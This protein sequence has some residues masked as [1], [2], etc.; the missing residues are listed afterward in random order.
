M[1]V[2]DKLSGYTGGFIL[3]AALYGLVACGSGASDTELVE[4]AKAYMAENQPREAAIELKN[5][6][7]SNPD[8]AEARYLLGEIQLEVGDIASAEKEFERSAE[9]GWLDELAKIEIA[10]SL[11]LQRKFKEMAEDVTAGSNW[12]KAAKADLLGL[13]AVAEAGMGDLVKARVTLLEGEKLQADALYVLETKAKLQLLEG[14]TSKAV[15]TLD[16]A[17]K[18]YP[19]SGELR[20]LA[21]NA[22]INNKDVAGARDFYE[23][24][25]TKEPANLITRN[26][27][28]AFIGVTRLSILDKEYEQ[29]HEALDPLAKLNPDDP[30]VNYLAGVLAFEEKDYDQAEISLR[31]ILKLAPNHEPSL[32]LF[33]AVSYAQ[34]KFEQAAY[35]LSKYVSARPENL[36]ARKLLGRAYIALEQHENAQE[37]L[38]P[39]LKEKS[40]DAELLALDGLSLLRSGQAKAGIFELEKAVAL[41]PESAVLRS[42][43]ARAYMSSG[44]MEQAIGELEK[45]IA[46]GK[47]AYRAQV[48]VVFAYLRGKKYEEAIA[49]SQKMLD[50]YPDDATIT[51]LMGIVQYNSGHEEAGRKYFEKTL[52]IDPQHTGAAINLARLDEKAGDIEKARTRYKAILDN[53]AGNTTAL[54]AL[55]R[56]AVIQGDKQSQIKWL[57]KAREVDNEDAASRVVL[58]ETYIKNKDLAV[59][60]K[61]VK[62]IE[63]MHEGKP[64]A[65]IARAE[66]LMAR[67]SH[68]QA[69]SVIN[70]LVELRPDSFVGY[71]LKGMNQ[72]KLGQVEDAKT[73]FLKAD[74]LNP[75]HVRNLFLL[76]Q[77]RIGSREFKEGLKLGKRI[78]ELAPE[79]AVGFM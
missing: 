75:G 79:I 36:R 30:E 72:L 56:L 70:K 61:L 12:S 64:V 62:E 41:A 14:R 46:G 45:V 3:V 7:Q 74:E 50:E 17:M 53:E 57:E 51:N 24:I 6:L 9:L 32:L 21:A 23:E 11:I 77:I 54:K 38:R 68:N 8:N 5:A 47:D 19:E 59:A 35:Y 29:A 2:I 43:L 31:K 26:G 69:V 39:G 71:Y 33:G 1:R 78:T 37:A 22:A 34:N 73:S 40:E 27:R 67:E 65:L 48:M 52:Q 44:D 55:A 16:E 49:S 28:K 18:L 66:L 4:T 58:I 20:L 76:A 15:K 10:R 25:I 60:E 63:T 13:R 42:E